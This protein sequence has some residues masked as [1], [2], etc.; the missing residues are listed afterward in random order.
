MFLN[1][2]IDEA[3]E[4]SIKDITNCIEEGDITIESLM[5]DEVQQ[6][7]AGKVPELSDR[8]LRVI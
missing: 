2:D 5:I 6:E 1:G 8:F 4:K 7:E 3:P